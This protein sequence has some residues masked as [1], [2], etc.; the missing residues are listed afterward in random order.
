MLLIAFNYDDYN[1]I[2]SRAVVILLPKYLLGHPEN[3]LCSLSIKVLSGSKHQKNYVI[4]KIDALVQGLD[5][6]CFLPSP[7]VLW[8]L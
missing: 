4:L 5:C 6:Y 8:P 3:Y 7:S 1:F 2:L